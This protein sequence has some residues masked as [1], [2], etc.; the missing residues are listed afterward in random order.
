MNNHRMMRCHSQSLLLKQVPAGSMVLNKFEAVMHGAYVDNLPWHNPVL[1]TQF[2]VV[3]LVPEP[4]VDNGTPDA[5][6]GV[7][8]GCVPGR[9]GRVFSNAY[10]SSPVGQQK[11]SLGLTLN[12]K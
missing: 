10:N 1:D 5:F 8:H 3:V 6:Q 2:V 11:V 12:P 7:H 9:L 4:I